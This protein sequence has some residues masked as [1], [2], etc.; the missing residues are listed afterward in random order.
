M[1]VGTL[2]IGAVAGVLALEGLKQIVSL[3]IKRPME[4]RDARRKAARD[5]IATLIRKIDICLDAASE[6][7]SC[8]DATERLQLSSKVKHA[9]RGAGMQFNHVNQALL[10][11][12]LPALESPLL[13]G[14]RQ[15]TTMDLDSTTQ[16]VG[17][18]R[19]M[20]EKAYV[21]KRVLTELMLNSLV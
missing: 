20:Y 18:P 4:K 16:I 21:L 2:S 13:V 12:S 11:L 5:E 3:L 7:Y 6:Y 1:D 14:F 8:A 17:L 10:S 19:D 9:I 15:A